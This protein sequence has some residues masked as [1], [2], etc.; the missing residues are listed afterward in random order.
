MAMTSWSRA[1]A[2]EALRIAAEQ[3]FDLMILDVML[4]GLNGFE[5][6]R[7]VRERGI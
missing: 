6:C 7:A 2:A 4:P 3:R 1:M 5:L